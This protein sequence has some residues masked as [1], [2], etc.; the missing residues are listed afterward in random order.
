MSH[1]ALL[2]TAQI[3]SDA[4]TVGFPIAALAGAASFLSPCVLPLLPGYLSYVSGVSAVAVKEGK[5]SPKQLVLPTL[6]FVLGFSTIFVALGASATLAGSLVQSNRQVMARI[7][8]VLVILLGLAFLGLLPLRF[9]Y[10]E[11]RPQFRPERSFLGN[12]LLGIS[13]ALGWTPCIGPTLGATLL[14]ASQAETAGRGALLLGVYSLGLGVPFLLSALGVARLAGALSFFRRHQMA[15]LRASGVMLVAFGVLLFFDKV[16]VLSNV[17][18]RWMT[19]AGL[20]E[21]IGI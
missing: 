4:V 2:L 13:F 8:G 12:Y 18:Q 7:G 17:F 6:I 1:V 20:E 19:A 9:L 16:F 11:R 5:A 21:L 10:S 14:I 15:I 3:V